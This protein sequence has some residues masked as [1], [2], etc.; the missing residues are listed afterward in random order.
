MKKLFSTLLAAAMLASAALL[1][2]CG[3]NEKIIVHTNAYFAPF[4]YFVGTDIAG[5][6]VDVMNKVAE[7]MDTSVEFKSVEFSAIIDNV[8]AGK[9][10]DCG[11]AGIT[12]T[13]ERKEKVDF[14]IPYYTS[15]QYVIWAADDD[16]IETTDDKY[17]LWDVLAG[18][19]IGV[20][21]DTTGAIY[22]D[23]EINATEDNKD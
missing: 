17:V 15:V 1:T 7:K 4:E 8:S 23:G 13:D 9:V 21:T 18:K 11:A 16:S 3:D 2:S 6:D 19:D 12:I 10:C 20:Q 14:S 22:T 5:V